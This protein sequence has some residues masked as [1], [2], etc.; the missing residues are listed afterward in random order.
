MPTTHNPAGSPHQPTATTTHTSDD[1]QIVE[2]IATFIAHEVGV[3]YSALIED[4]AQ[5]LL[6]HM[7]S[8]GLT[9]TTQQPPTPEDD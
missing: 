4:Q 2:V 5:D 3:G 9:V 7:R 6:T 8:C 1:E